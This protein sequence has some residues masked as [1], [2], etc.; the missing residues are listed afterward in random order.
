MYCYMFYDYI[1]SLLLTSQ[2]CNKTKKKQLLQSA[3]AS[4]SSIPVFS[5]RDVISV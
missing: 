3:V 1:K 5:F 4:L 2:G